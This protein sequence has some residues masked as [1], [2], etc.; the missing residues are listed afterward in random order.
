[1]VLT[2]GVPNIMYVEPCFWSAVL[3]HVSD[4]KPVS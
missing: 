2:D 1:M 3:Y 4:P